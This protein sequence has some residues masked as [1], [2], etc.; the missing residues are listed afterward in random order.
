MRISNQF[1]SVLFAVLNIISEYYPDLEPLRQDNYEDVLYKYFYWV[2]E[3]NN[4]YDPRN[5]PRPEFA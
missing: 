4:G 5:F 3:Y 2:D 1:R